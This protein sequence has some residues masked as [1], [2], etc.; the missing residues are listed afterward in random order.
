MGIGSG[1]NCIMLGVDWQKTLVRG[2]RM[3]ERTM[4]ARERTAVRA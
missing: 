1:V 4:P 3:D 2:D